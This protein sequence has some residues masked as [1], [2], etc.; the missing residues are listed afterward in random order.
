MPEWLKLNYRYTPLSGEHLKPIEAMAKGIAGAETVQE[1]F[2]ALFEFA[3]RTTPASGIFVAHY[4]TDSGLRRCVYS[5]DLITTSDGSREIEED[6]DLDR[7]PQVP[8]NDGPQSKAILT[9]AVVNTPDLNSA[10]T[11]LPRFDVGSDFDQNPPR[12]SLA[13]PLA[14]EGRTL[15]VFEVQ[16]PHLDAFDE[17]HVAGLS[18][19]ARLAGIAV[20]NLALLEQVRA[21]REATLRALGIALEYRDYETKGHTDRVVT[22]SL[23]F[24]QMLA[25]KP[26]QLQ[27]LKWGAYL[28]DIGKIAIPDQIL[29]KP[30][31]LSEE[32]LEAVHHHTLIGVE[33]CGDIPFLAEE[34][35][36]VVRNHH[37]SWD[38]LGY[39]DKLAGEDIPLLARMFALADVYDAL[40]SKRPYKQVWNHDKAV[41]EIREKAGAQFDPHLVP[42]FIQVLQ[43]PGALFKEKE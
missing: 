12:S 18:M 41:E 36:Q 4:S 20:E 35:L 29:L 6:I 13:V 9:G 24:G 39:P 34:T 1:V 22:L 33:M 27:A 28:H 43:R 3:T 11:G 30:G 23:A 5:A 10:A 42:T 26:D 14:V 32:E 15:G 40:T 19:A 16:S 7:Y 31:A 21:Q 37:E 17:S 8:L 2:R 25:F 38:G